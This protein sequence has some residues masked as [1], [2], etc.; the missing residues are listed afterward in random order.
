[1]LEK[2]KSEHECGKEKRQR[3]EQEMCER[4]DEEKK[5][6]KEGWQDFNFKLRVFVLLKFHRALVAK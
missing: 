4:I 2:S 5:A 3:T 1:M 6:G